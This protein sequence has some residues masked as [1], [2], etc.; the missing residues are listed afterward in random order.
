M[1]KDCKDR[2]EAVGPSGARRRRKRDCGNHTCGI[3]RRLCDGD[4]PWRKEGP[5][6]TE[7]RGC[8]RLEQTLGA[9]DVE[10]CSCWFP[11]QKVGWV[12]GCGKT[13][14]WTQLFLQ[15]SAAAG[16]VAAGG[17]ADWTALTGRTEIPAP[18]LTPSFLSLLRLAG[19]RGYRR[20]YSAESQLY[21]H[22]AE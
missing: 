21:R 20:N 4:Q 15:L 13:P 12:G 17:D 6:S 8:V 19:A 14:K 16:W 7:G 10:S 11:W 9:Q 1:L 5:E 2:E 18:F 3:C 22:Q